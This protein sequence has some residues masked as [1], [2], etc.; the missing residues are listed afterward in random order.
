MRLHYD[1]EADVLY[2]SIGEPVPSYCEDEDGYM[3]RYS[4]ETGNLS[5]MTVI[6]TGTGEANYMLINQDRLRQMEVTHVTPM[7][8]VK[9][10]EADFRK[11]VKNMLTRLMADELEI[12]V[13]EEVDPITLQ[14]KFTGKALYLI[15]EK[16][17]R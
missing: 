16:D 8:I 1:K 3:L 10:A 4:Q 11:R 5:G 9:T 7:H 6:G 14:V 15:P 12:E 17:G 2:V 13:Q